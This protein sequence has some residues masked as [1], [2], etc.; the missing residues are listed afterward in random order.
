MKHLDIVIE[1]LGPE[2]YRLTMTSNGEVVMSELF[3]SFDSVE[4]ENANQFYIILTKLE[5]T[6]VSERT[7]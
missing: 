5:T 3:D 7:H 1:T 4:G 6:H 2:S